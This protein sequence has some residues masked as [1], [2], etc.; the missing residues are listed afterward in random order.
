MSSGEDDTISLSDDDILE[1]SDNLDLEGKILGKYNIL[2]ELGKGSYSIVWLGYSIENN[3]FYAIK[4]QHPNE[5]KVGMEENKFMKKLPKENYYFNNLIDEFI[6][7]QDDKKFL[8][9]VYEL[10][11]CNID[12]VLRKGDYQA[13]LPFNIVM[14]IMYQLL[15]CINYLHNKLK[16]YHGDIKT[17]N[18]LIKGV[19]NKNKLLIDLYTKYNFLNLYS[20]AKKEYGK[21]K[22]SSQ[23]KLKIR[24]KIHS[25]IY[26]NILNELTEIDICKYDIDNEL[27]NNC[28]ISLS[29]FGSFVED[30]E[31]YDIQFGTRY[32]R[33]PENILIGKSSYPNDIWALGCTLYEMLT[34]EILFDPDKDKHFSRDD[35]HLKEIENICGD[36]SYDFIKS[37]KD[38][39]KYFTSNGKLKCNIELPNNKLD[40]LKKNVGEENYNIIYNILMNMLHINPNKRITSVELL[41]LF[42]IK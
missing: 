14:K 9:S 28:N 22:L 10:H 3:N 20:Q 33:S 32:Y 5:Y 11:A 25:D 1:H 16:V 23:K 17:D 24:K 35:Y 37:T 7:K 4:V 12:T 41:K 31:Y 15:I 2:S 27:I 13:G 38:Y 26:K 21:T 39:K 42:A 18:I 30:G 8:C 19:T 34:G 29:D 36:F 40:V 6:E